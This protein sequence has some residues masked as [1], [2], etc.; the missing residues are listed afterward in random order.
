VVIGPSS[1]TGASAARYPCPSG[2]DPDAVKASYQDGVLE[3]RVHVDE[4]QAKGAKVP[5]EHA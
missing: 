4:V 2:A 1:G 3:V 5:V